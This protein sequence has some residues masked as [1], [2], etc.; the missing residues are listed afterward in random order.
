MVSNIIF[1][2]SNRI[3]KQEPCFFDNSKNETSNLI[4]LTCNVTL[5]QRVLES[6]K[7]INLFIATFWCI[8]MSLSIFEN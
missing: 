3:G 1:F 8:S 7:R 6:S 4:I 5:V 2:K